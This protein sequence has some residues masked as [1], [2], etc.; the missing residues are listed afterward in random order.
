VNTSRYI[1]AMAQLHDQ[2]RLKMKAAAEMY[3][4]CL[5]RMMEEFI[6]SSMEAEREL[7]D[8]LNALTKNL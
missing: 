3:D 4:E 8:E 2:H 5:T 7:E 1:E 6:K